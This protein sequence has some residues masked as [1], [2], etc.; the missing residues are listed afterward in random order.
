MHFP[1]RTFR[2]FEVE[3]R[4]TNVGEQIMFGGLSPVGFGEIRL[5]DD[6]AGAAPVVV[7]EVVRMPGDLLRAA[8]GASAGHPLLLLM[9]RDRVLPAPSRTDPEPY[10]TRQFTLPDARTFAVAGDVRLAATGP[11][12]RSTARWAT[13]ARSSRTPPRVSWTRPVRASAALD[14]D[15]STAW[16]TPFKQAVGSWIDV[17]PGAPTTLDHLDLALVADGRHSVPTE[18]E[19]DNRAGARRRVSLDPPPDVTTPD[20]TVAAPPTSRP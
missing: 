14:D 10:L 17:S 5:R 20:G 4:G 2:S 9:S 12:P 3:V 19:V 15:R 16:V 6:A 7:H 13:R 18:I 8:K 1:R 11:T